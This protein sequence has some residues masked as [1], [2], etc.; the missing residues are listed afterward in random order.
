[1][2]FLNSLSFNR[3]SLPVPDINVG[4]QFEGGVVVISHDSQLLSR[5]CDNAEQA[6]VWLVEDGTVM[7]YD[8]YF[9]VRPPFPHWGKALCFCLSCYPTIPQQKQGLSSFGMH[10]QPTFC[11]VCTLSSIPIFKDLLSKGL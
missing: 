7:R 4:V 6:E 8:G 1:M 2:W 3:R 10:P 9:E 11:G 5:V